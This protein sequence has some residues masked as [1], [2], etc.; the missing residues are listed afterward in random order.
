MIKAKFKS[1]IL[2]AV[3]L[4]AL[5]FSTLVIAVPI[6][7]EL[8]VITPGGEPELSV[9]T[10]KN[11]AKCTKTGP[12]DCIEVAHNTSPFIHFNLA[13]ACVATPY[14]LKGIRIT[15]VEKLWPTPAT[16]LNPIATA[17]F[18]ADP[19]SGK[20][21]LNADNNKLRDKKIKFKNRNSR[22]Y[23]V[24]YEI[25]AEHCTNQDKDDIHLDPEIRNKGKG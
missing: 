1:W 12:E 7:V 15:L 20:I 25:T 22:Q 2:F 19:H 17:D 4:G 21:D 6:T 11:S 23:T 3:L 5:C 10:G 14:K 18:S 24:F 13:T 8:E 16:P 9:I